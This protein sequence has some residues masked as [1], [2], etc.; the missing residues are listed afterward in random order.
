MKVKDLIEKLK[1]MDPEAMVITKSNN[2][3]MNGADVPLS[4]AHQYE[5]GSREVQN[6]RD[7]FDGCPY[8]SVTYSITGGD[9]RVVYL[10]G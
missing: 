9:L 6:F 2:F 10:R 5:T 1:G 3:E 8:S 7:A 4:R